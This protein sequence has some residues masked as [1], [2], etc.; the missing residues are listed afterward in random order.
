MAFSIVR[1]TNITVSDMQ[2][3]FNDDVDPN[4]GITNVSI[5][6]GSGNIPDPEVISVEVENETVK[7]SYRP[8]FPG[9]KYQVVFASTS[10]VP[11][12]TVNGERITEDGNRN[13]I[14]VTSPGEDENAIRDSMLDSISPIYETDE[15]TLTRTL[16]TAAADTLQ[17]AD[18][19]IQTTRAGNYL[20]VL[21]EDER[22]TRDSGPIDR[23]A[24]GGAYEILR[25]ASVPTT[26]DR[27]T[28]LEFNS[29][30]YNSF[31]VRSG[32][33]INP[34]LSNIT[35][36]PISLQSVDVINEKVT[37][38]TS[39]NNYFDG[40][41]IKVSKHPVIQVISV[42]LKR[43]GEWT[44]YNIEEFGYVLQSNRYD[45]NL[46]GINVNLADNEIELS[47]SSLTGFEGGFTRPRA[48]DEIRVSYVYKNLGRNIDPD[49][50]ALT[51]VKNVV[52]ETTPAIINKF[53]VDHAPVVTSLDEIAVSNGIEFLSTLSTD[54]LQAFS[55]THP[56][57]IKEVKYDVT[58]FPARIGEYTINYETG[59]VVVFGEDD[60]NNG[61]GEN[62]PA[63]NYT[64]RQY[65]VEDLD[66]TFN[67]D[68]DE[69]A[70]SSI[71]SVSGI[72]AKI[73]FNYEDVFAVNEDYKVRSHVEVLNER[74]NN[75]L[76]GEYTIQTENFPVTNVFRILNET[77]GE[78]YATE[79]FNDTS[80]VFSGRQA[81][82]QVGVERERISF[83]QIPQEV[84]LIAEESTNTHGLRIF[85]IELENSGITDSQSRSIGA[86][87]DT[88]ILFSDSDVF[89]REFFYEDRI[90][91]SVS[92]NLDRLQ[93]VG[94][95]IVDYTNGIVY[96]AVTSGQGPDIGDIS[97]QHKKIQ[98]RHPHI[99]GVDDLY[100]SYSALQPNVVTYSV[101]DIT[102]TTINPVGLESVGER[103]I[104]NNTSRVLV[105][106]T[107][108][109][110]E[111]GIT[112]NG[113]N[114]F[115]SNTAVFT[116]E[117]VGRTI[118][119]GSTLSP[120]VQDVT[121][122][123]IVS[124]H[125]V[126]VSPDFTY[127]KSG[128]A[129]TVLDLSTGAPKTLTLN[130]D[131]ISV[132]DIY[133]V[134]QVGA[135][136]AT[137][138]DGYYDINRDTVYG[139][140]ITLGATNGLNV[141]DAVIVNYNYGN[142]YADYSYV[143]DEIVISYE[144]GNNSLD[145]SIS[146]TLSAGQEYFVT[147]KYGALRDSLLL[148][149]GSL[150]QISQL[151]NFSP[152]LNRELYRSILSGTLQSFVEGPTIPSIERLVEAFTD[153]VPNITET[154]FSNWVLG[155]DYLHLRD[156]VY[157][158]TPIY[159][160]GKFKNGLVV[161]ADQTIQVPA[162]SHLKLDE[163]TIET[164]IRPQWSGS[165]NDAT[166]TF[167]VAIDGY[168]DP[169]KVYIGFSGTNPTQ[170]P[171]SISKDDDSIE[172]ISEPINIDTDTG[173]FIWYDDTD[174]LWHLRWRE[175]RDEVHE[176]TGTISTSGEFFNIVQPT[177][178]DGYS[179]NESTDVITSTIHQ[180]S[181][182]A[183]I[184]GYDAERDEEMY[185]LDGVS[186]ASGDVHYLF[187][188]AY[189]PSSNRM[190]LFKDGT[191]YLNFQVF[192]N[193]N[194]FN[195]PAGFYNL[196][197]NIRDW[198]E[199]QLHHIAVAW[200]FNSA[201]ERDEMHLFVNGYEVKNLFKYGGNP[202]ASNL[203]DFG[204]VAEETIITSA[205]RPI[206]HASDG[207]TT[208]GSLIFRIEDGDFDAA[209]IEVGDSLYIL[210][211]IPDG[212]GDP[213]FGLPY[214]ITGVGTTT[215]TLDR[216]PT[217]TLGDISFSI[218]QITATV[219][220]PL[221]FQDF[222]VVT[223]D[224]DGNETE[225]NGVD[226]DS[227][228]YTIRRGSDYSHV[229]T[230]N[231]GI[232]VGDAVVIHPIGLVFKRCRER[233]YVYGGGYSELRVNSAAPVTLDDVNITALI[234]EKTLI[235]T[236]GGFGIVGTV[237]GAQL[238][239]L[240]QSHF[241]N[242]CQPSNSSAGRKLAVRLT[243]DNINYDIPG[244][245][246][247]ISGKTYSGAI[248]ETI[249]FTENG[250]IVTDEY[251]TEIDSIVVSIIPIDATQP[252][253]TIEIKENSPITVSENNGDFAEVVEYSNGIIRL[254]T[255][256]AGGI[257]FI[258]NS[259]KY[260][261]DYPSFLRIRLDKQPDTFFIGSDYNGENIVD[262][263]IDEFRIIDNMATD[264]RPGESLVSGQ[265]SITTDYTTEVPF[266]EDNNTLLLLHY[267]DVSTDSSDFIDRF[268][269]GFEVAPSV[270]SDFGTG[271][272]FATN[273]P[274]IIN[275]ADAI[276]NNTEGSIEFW[277]SPLDD[278]RGDPNYHYYVDMTSVFEEE[279]ESVTSITVIASQSIRTIESV[280]LVSDVYNTGT[281]YYTGGSISNIDNKTITLGIPLPGQNVDV[282]VT[283]VPINSYGDQVSIFRDPHGF[284]NFF[285]KASG[286]EH[287]ISVHVDWQRHT[288]HRIMAMW[289]TNSVN[290][291]DRMRLFVDGS[292][293]GTIKY[294]TGLIYGTGIIYG[295]AE[296]RPGVN[297]FLVDNIDLRDTFA[298]IYV[299]ADTFSFNGAR[300]IMDNLRFSDEQ[301]LT[302][303]RY[304]Y[305]QTIDINYN[306][307]EF[308]IP[309]VEDI[310]TTALYNFDT[311][312]DP[313]DYLATL[314]DQER[315]IFR[316][317][318]EV[319]DSFDKV[320]GNTD[321]ENLLAELIDTIKPAHTESI[322]TLTE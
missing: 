299:G 136:P 102:D 301:R 176:F 171:F 42:S 158:S 11:F 129:W 22:V 175:L 264:T 79:R 38:D 277:V 216:A 100:R 212:T 292:E 199:N 55:S 284:V 291:R 203:F 189:T 246:V 261:V 253:G 165:A 137:S 283:Y 124:A 48:G 78:L 151:T 70:L 49:S 190:S 144:Y 101:G 306:V 23:L 262:A 150:T 69:L 25:V 28:Y 276:F 56:A 3:L 204:D 272:K 230:L 140:V 16:I 228:D 44:E 120:P 170:I 197:T 143:K 222:I 14:F 90:F 61:T 288:W 268:G 103:F 322:I 236:G 183:F 131:I 65:F 76:L 4:V 6:S 96:V 166:L 280:R 24:N 53:N 270:N 191:G 294:G 206:I 225:L 161:S 35:S 193:S 21:V 285:V 30:R 7:L 286:V 15:Q 27:T 298:R 217:Q 73:T 126:L 71:R 133:L 66:F 156:I 252:A 12:S 300:A 293:R 218:N 279:I 145:W 50:I 10:T 188:M 265:T 247:I 162:I 257:P 240:L 52:R 95:Y 316:F 46:A 36:D 195:L 37:D 198:E 17:R 141:G 174:N 109:N 221:N 271:I 112:T 118:R 41:T 266:E 2:I 254:E 224:G 81:P 278:V 186:F 74:V 307:A 209:G 249:L 68:R 192:D 233:V 194:D 93:Q 172:T 18:D 117:D 108:Q 9:V 263:V 82:R 154:A 182:D 92:D 134:G 130:Y 8:L 84:L 99:I 159:D 315:G 318:V 173:F 152:N 244:N 123:D 163:G 213:N 201:D 59:E 214:T 104:N 97:Y 146:D 60:A 321:L 255:Y 275:N 310:T 259:C 5:L 147:Y 26:V 45:T 155:R 88:S 128:R 91:D 80:V 164:W 314:I 243:G 187:D 185:A 304:A 107:H 308:A 67:S 223:I 153:V 237:I 210:E 160:T 273:K 258:L 239:T 178:P 248:S 309:V 177:G 317:E 13:S 303:V 1:I 132:R 148:N 72:E 205:S 232:D 202:K 226:A 184:D 40:L 135:L 200:K 157:G 110:G 125:E 281:N 106:G 296:V 43:D 290:N 269:E 287:V 312:S 94:D 302:T 297:R 20:S 113:D 313:V 242:P 63:I 227:P 215:L 139:N 196:S 251:W 167:D 179:I 220:I 289:S 250:S 245:Q 267:N 319:I 29:T 85:K 62:P 180:I 87:F 138:L 75:R 111:D 208:A 31:N 89:I 116:S 32:V 115:T 235:E 256:G 149:F 207:L 119:V 77:T 122:T 320:I 51:T 54:T 238:V 19:A 33:I 47:S 260:E 39:L 58:R 114:L 219:T 234:L 211:D 305:N 168:S 231:N 121:I 282:K 34:I 241:D 105:V 295:Q 98:T 142:V 127:T 57:F 311:A 64:Y 274:Y 169:T 86:N 181:F 83:S 229:I